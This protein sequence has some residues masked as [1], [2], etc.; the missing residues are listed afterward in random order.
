MRPAPDPIHAVENQSSPLED[1]NS[2]TS[3]RA[4][5]EAVIREGAEWAVDQL[6]EA[7]TKFAEKNSFRLAALANTYVPTLRTHD[8]QGRRVDEVD[9]HPAW[10]E[11][12]KMSIERGIVALAWKN[13]RT[14][15]QVA[16]AA[17]HYLYS[18]T[19]V[20]TEC[21]IAMSYGVVPVLQKFSEDWAEIGD[22]WLPRLLS[23]SYDPRFIPASQKSGVLFGMGMTERQ[24]G[25]DV[26][27]NITTAT[28]ID[29]GGLGRPYRIR[30]HKWFFSAPMCD[31]FLVLAQ[32]ENGPSCFLV[33]RFVADSGLN[34]LRLLRLKDK[35]GN[36]S[37]A[38]SEV[39]FHDATGY[40]LG[41]EGRGVNTIIEMAAHTRLDCVLATT[42]MQRRAL[43]VAIHH[44]KQ[45]KAFSATLI[46]KPMMANVLADL[47]VES[48]ATTH[49]AMYLARTFEPEAPDP[50]QKIGRILTPAA[51]YH[52]CKRGPQFAAEAIEVLGGNGYVEET[53]LARIYREMPLLSIWEGSG[54]VMCLDLQRGIA[55]EPDTVQALRE[56]LAAVRGADDRLDKFG[57]NVLAALQNPAEAQ[58]RRLAHGLVLAVQGALLVQHA[59]APVAE[60]FCGTRLLPATAWGASFGTLP[61]GAPTREILERGAPGTED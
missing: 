39:E 32:T 8:R 12:L 22:L 54:N 2:F 4:L 56:K 46:E 10:H 30:G 5:Q 36:H 9:F 16:R 43:S 33:P 53:D 19:E 11:L 24:G 57:E 20:G 55:R 37:N 15:S 18:Q 51:K 7:G 35:L 3:D 45:R 44:A 17:L 1:F 29:N 6:S 27:S 13:P 25:S 14:G 50:D 26:R 38:S 61:D 40:L 31:A 28:P 49:L 60:T 21:P 42:G 34:A 59:P 48:E 52:V 41:D 47:A 23:G 58:G